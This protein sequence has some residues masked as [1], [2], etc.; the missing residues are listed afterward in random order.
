MRSWDKDSIAIATEQN[1]RYIEL[2][3]AK[4]WI[5][6]NASLCHELGFGKLGHIF[7]CWVTY[8]HMYMCRYDI[9]DVE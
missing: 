7:S 4:I 3:D 5:S 1:F 8:L 9:A 2:T 6:K